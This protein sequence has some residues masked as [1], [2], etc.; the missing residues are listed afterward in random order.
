MDNQDVRQMLP[1]KMDRY[2]VDLYRGWDAFERSNHRN[3]IIDF[4]LAP[5]RSYLPVRDRYEVLAKLNK[6]I[7]DLDSETTN[8]AVLIRDRLKASACYLRVLL[9]ESIS[10]RSYIRQ[11]LGIEPRLFTDD[12][13]REQRSLVNDR[14]GQQYEMSFSKAE[15]SRF[16]ARFMIYNTDSLPEKFELFRVK[17]VPELLKRVSVPMENYK[18]TVKFAEE[19]AYWKNWISGNLSEHQILLRINTHPRQSWYQGFPEMLVIHE[20]CGHAVQMVKWHCRIENRELPEFAGILTVHFPD[21][22]LLEGLA[23]SL[24]FV[25][26]DQQKLEGQSLV[27]RELHRYYLSVMNNV[28]IL[29]NEQGLQTAID[30]ATRHLPFSSSEA[31]GREVRDRTQNPLFRGYQYVY[32]IAKESFLSVL[33]QLESKQRWELLR[34][35]YDW[36]MTAGQF[37]NLTAEYV[38]SSPRS[39]FSVARQP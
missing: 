26:P 13:I 29:A 21:Q 9:G 25:L 2:L 8:L 30:Y 22:F 39:G 36:P 16:Q 20:Y 12:V 38:A 5:P 27:S 24:A 35:V 1:E 14:L 15:I 34:I 37:G 19:D 33:S 31:I 10:F 17:W 6:A 32:G 11:T 4:D 7:A 23:E 3:S 28:H 18:V